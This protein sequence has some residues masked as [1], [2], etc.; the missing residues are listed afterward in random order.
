MEKLFSLLLAFTYFIF[1]VAK[2]D[3]KSLELSKLVNIRVVSQTLLLDNVFDCSGREC[4]W[5]S[6]VLCPDN[7]FAYALEVK[8]EEPGHVDETAINGVRLYCSANG[9]D[10]GYIESSNGPHG[11]YLGMKICPEDYVTGFRAN[12]LENQGL[13]GEDV[14]V[15]DIEM[16]CS[17]GKYILSSGIPPVSL[18]DK[19]MALQNT[20][21]D[22][23]LVE[24]S[25][26]VA[27]IVL[28]CCDRNESSHNN[29][30]K[31]SQNFLKTF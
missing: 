2:A 9:H 12:V 3:L 18:Q 27:D 19:K 28:F 11:D 25:I 1:C 17:Y 23:G 29:V 7:G 8:Y 24:D 6:I 21:V 5:G 20:S 16:D 22:D 4:I 10:L 15:E 30:L 14:A 26:S 13:I 31:S